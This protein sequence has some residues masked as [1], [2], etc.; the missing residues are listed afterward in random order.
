MVH[1]KLCLNCDKPLKGRSDKKFCDDQCRS[2]YNY[3]Q[4]SL[5]NVN[6]VRRVNSALKKNRAILKAFNINGETKVLK[7]ALIRVGFD[8]EYYTNF[9]ETAN[10]RRYYFCYEMGY[11]F[12]NDI[13]ILLIEEKLSPGSLTKR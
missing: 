2:S 3:I 1:G 7:R 13:E 5:G 9:Y 12:I 4:N 10:S 11:L 8:F 6:F